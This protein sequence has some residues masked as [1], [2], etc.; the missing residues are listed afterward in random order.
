[1]LLQ[2]STEEMFS[3]FRFSVEP[4]VLKFLH[5]HTKSSHDG[6]NRS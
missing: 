6:A 5:S 4:S 2:N 1:M 3:F